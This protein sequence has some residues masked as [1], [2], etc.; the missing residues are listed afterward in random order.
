MPTLND[1]IAQV[2]ADFGGIKR[3]LVNKGASIPSGTP[4]SQYANIIKNMST[5]NS[6]EAY[7]KGRQDV[8]AESKYIPKSATGKIITLTDVSEVAHKVKVVGV[9]NEVEVYGKNLCDYTKAEARSSATTVTIVD[10]GVEFTGDFYFRIPVSL[11]R[12]TT[13]SF[14]F[15][16]GASTAQWCFAYDGSNNISVV[17]YLNNSLTTKTDEDVKYIYVYPFSTSGGGTVTIINIQLELGAASTK[18]ES[19]THQTIMATPLGTEVSS[20]CPNMTFIADE[21]IQVNYY[22]SFGMA[23]KELAMWN[24][25][26]NFGAKSDWRLSFSHTNFSGYTIPTGLCRP[27]TAIGNMFAQYRGNELPRGVDC[28]DFDAT[29]TDLTYHCYYTFASSTSLKHIYDMGIPAV[30]SYDR[31]Y[32][33]CTSLV[34]IEIIRSDENSAFSVNCFNNC[35]KLTHVIFSGIIASDINLQWSPLLDDESLVSISVAL[36]DLVFSGLGDGWGSRTLTLSAESIARLKELP[37]PPDDLNP[38]GQP[39]AEDGAS[40]Y[41]VIV[42]RKGW[43]IA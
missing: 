28:S 31:A 40:C 11:N 2:K 29:K 21:D 24:A 16:G 34:R 1:N 22:S 37:Y 3:E 25:I 13:Y 42:G 26:T 4:T 17:K 41:E 43:N 18:Y 33:N 20:L 9:G 10:G 36:C 14:N 8:I 5:G 39:Y 38:E 7:E 30:K 23:E 35:P 27:T 32:Y 15:S 6:E 12:G 19:Y